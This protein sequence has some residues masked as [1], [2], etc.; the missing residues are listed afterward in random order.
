MI[1]EPEPFGVIEILPF[2]ADVIVCPLTSKF[3]PN[4]G[5][6][7]STTSDD[8]ISLV[9][10]TVPVAFGSVIVLSAVGSVTVSVVSCASAVDPSNR[11]VFPVFNKTPSVFILATIS[12]EPPDTTA[13][14]IKP[15]S[16]PADASPILPVIFAYV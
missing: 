2:D 10:A 6:V 16:L 5:E 15:S 7:S 14:S 1:T 12:F 11:S 9:N 8:V 4:C 3:P 13:N